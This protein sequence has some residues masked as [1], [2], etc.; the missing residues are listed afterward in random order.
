MANRVKLTSSD[1]LNFDIDH[2]EIY[3]TFKN[4]QDLFLWLDGDNSCFRELDWYTLEKTDKLRNYQY[5]ISIRKD[6]RT[7]FAWYRG[8]QLNEYIET[9]DYFVAYWTAFQVLSLPEILDFIDTYIALDY[10]DMR[11]WK[12]SHTVKRLDI[13]LDIRK[14]I[15]VLLSKFKDLKQKWSKF[16]DERGNVQTYYI[17]EKKPTKNK[18]LLIRVYDKIADIYQKEKQAY[19]PDYLKEDFITRIELEFRSELLK[20]VKL[21]QFLDRSYSF[22]I[23]CLYLSKHTNLLKK[24]ENEDVCKLTRYDKR[25]DM[26][27]LHHRQLTRNRYVNTF[28]WYA[29]K[30]L[31]LRWCPVDILL[32]EWIYKEETIQDMFY[33]SDYGIFNITEYKD[34][35]TARNLRKVFA[36][37]SKRQDIDDS[38]RS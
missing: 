29:K 5:K 24:F 14:D 2:V 15:K 18:A 27:D 21:S 4:Y 9:R 19:Y 25:I 30:F 38:R 3:G 11:K 13:A 28:L 20:Y 17:G 6:S 37:N 35:V 22:G 33:A 31:S 23:Y 36:D 10:P 8:D 34:W 1:F 32:R 7:L 16:F 12:K 26:E